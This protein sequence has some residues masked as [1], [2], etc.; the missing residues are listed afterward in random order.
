MRATDSFRRGL[1]WLL[2]LA[3]FALYLHTQGSTLVPYRDAGEMA[4]SVTRLGVLHPPGYPLYTLVGHLFTRLPLA[5]P[6]YRLNL[7]SAVAMAGTWAMLLLLGV[8]L[9]GAPA[10]GVMTALG[11]V[12]FQF[13]THALVSEMYTLNLLAIA[14]VLWL[15]ERRQFNAAALVF[16]LG[17]GARMDIVLCGPAFAAL[18]FSRVDRAERSRRLAQGIGFF[19]LGA[20]VF[21]YLLLRARQQPLWNWGD[22]S[23]FERFW[24]SIVRRSY[25][26]TLDLLSKS[27]G[28]GENFASELRLYLKHLGRDFTLASFPCALIGM[29]N[30]WR[31]RR[32]WFWAVAIGWLAA[33]PLFIY[34]GNLPPNPHAVAI[35]EASYLSPDLFYLL[36]IGAGIAALRPWPY[37]FGGAIALLGILIVA[38]GTRFYPALSRRN[39]WIA[40]DFIHNVFYAVP[41]PS[42]VV[43]HSDVPI[44]SLFYG[45]GVY[46][47]FKWRVPVAQGL[48][49]SPWYQVM[50]QRQ[51][52]KLQVASF[53]QAADWD[54]MAKANPGWSI[55]GTPDTDWP[56]ELYPRMV[57]AG[58]LLQ[59]LPRGARSIV[60]SETLLNEYG[61]YRGRYRYDAYHE[62]F[63]PELIEEYAKAWM[64]WGRLLLRSN[65]ADAAI[66][67]FL[68]ALALKPDMP[69]AAFQLGYIYFSRNDLA[70]ADYYYHWCT[71][72]FQR[73][74][75]QAEAWKALPNVRQGVRQDEAQAIAHWGVIQERTGDPER[76]AGLYQ[77][78]LRVDPACADARYN[79]AVLYWRAQ[80]WQDVVDQLRA[81]S[82]AHPD[83]PRWRTYLPQALQRLNGKTK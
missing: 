54:A 46:P 24:A 38:Q 68:H 8:E 49:A 70:R 58:L 15:L 76:A 4:T 57:S 79:L 59:F 10:A 67:A 29:A 72:N 47:G 25:G 23:T 21:L 41:E 37:A 35:M 3:A 75:S 9:I 12:S 52:P 73:M 45:Q 42:V 55:Y 33:G 71:D 30:L 7:L 77:Q 2:P 5:N 82:A 48:S 17:M 14:A 63:T 51:M 56:P 60:T 1:I 62:F 26:G 66:E 50:M 81:L 6:A 13:W 18:F 74:D 20:S 39:N 31:E 43:A 32:A 27:Y 34:L 64:D 19:L 36:A 78:A 80:R 83:D 53:L 69:Y 61:V 22:P 44:F 40:A 28:A 65:Q 11:V 16:G